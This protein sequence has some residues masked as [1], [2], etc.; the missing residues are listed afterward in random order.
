MARN[1]KRSKSQKAKSSKK[2]AQP[3]AP[4]E[5]TPEPVQEATPVVETPVQQAA[6]PAKRTRKPRTQK[7]VVE[8]DTEQ[9]TEANTEVAPTETET[10]G[11]RRRR[12]FKV[13]LPNSET[14]EGRF[15]GI[16]PYQAA[17]KALSKYYK[18]TKKP[19]KKIRFQ[20]RESTRGRTR[21]NVVHTYDGS[22]QKLKTP[23]EYTIK[24]SDGEEKVI[25]KNY[26]NHLVKVKKAELAE[27]E[28]ATAT[29]AQ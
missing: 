17:N 16:S 20:L 8:T 29:A 11:G 10:V 2:A 12:T 28:T 3:A 4:V 23:I 6:A 7:K 21:R 27:T 26:K 24:S 22:R 13:M 14:F 1:N 5:Q 15:I 19:A 18:E 25:T 9:V